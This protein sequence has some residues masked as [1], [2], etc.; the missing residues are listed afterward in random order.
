VALVRLPIT[1]IDVALRSPAGADDL[2][3]LEGGPLDMR[4]AVALLARLVCGPDG[5]A[6]D[7][8]TLPISDVDVLL[9]RLRQQVVGDLVSA[10][11]SCAARGCGARVDITFSIEA[12]LS[13]HAPVA[14]AALVAIGDGWFCL[15]EQAVEL[16]PPRAADHLAIAHAPDPEQAL[17]A[18]CV[19]PTP[20]PD[21]LR[22]VIEDALEA[23]APILHAE[24]EGTCPA[25]GIAV[26]TVFDPLRYT[27]RELRDQAAFVYDDVCAIA[28]HFHWSE[29]EILALPAPR[30]TRYAELAAERAQHQRTSA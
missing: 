1:G 5:A 20:P 10:E 7:P 13:H 30:R 4:L 9:L 22:S 26:V 18:R 16:R 29:A 27:L 21:P 15:T 14:Q 23:I 12:F 17:L 3:L 11:T 24:L 25:C 6:I 28:H 2:L 8:A 19:R